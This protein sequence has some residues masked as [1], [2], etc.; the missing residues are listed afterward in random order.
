[1]RL[2]FEALRLGDYADMDLYID[3]FKEKAKMCRGAKIG[4]AQTDDDVL[5]RQRKFVCSLGAVQSN[6][7]CIA[8]KTPAAFT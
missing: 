1:M 2:E 4:M 5:F 6:R 8:M 7:F 3:A